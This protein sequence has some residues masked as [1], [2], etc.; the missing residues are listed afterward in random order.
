[1]TLRVVNKWIK[2][3]MKKKQSYKP[4]PYQR[5][6]YLVQKVQID[7]KYVPSCCVVNG[8]K[9]YQYTAVDECTRWTFREMYDEHSTYSSR[10]FLL[11][12][13]KAFPAPIRE[14]QTDNGRGFTNA[15]LIDEKKYN[16]RSDKI[17][18]VKKQAFMTKSIFRLYGFL[19]IILSAILPI[20]SDFVNA[21]FFGYFEHLTSILSI[22]GL[23]MLLVSSSAFRRFMLGKDDDPTRFDK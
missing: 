17:R 4:K 10:D 2:P 7:V 8:Q 21:R 15:Y 9:Y 13:I 5:A 16:V 3:E 6:E 14:I 23:L 12:L 20:V 11:K 18:I 19:L 1:M 22:V